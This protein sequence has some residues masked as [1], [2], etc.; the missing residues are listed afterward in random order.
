VLNGSV[1]LFCSRSC[2]SK[3]EELGVSQSVVLDTCQW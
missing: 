2:S 1:G 3:L